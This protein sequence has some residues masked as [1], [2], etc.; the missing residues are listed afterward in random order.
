MA[1][2]RA[3]T[4]QRDDLFVDAS[5]CLRMRF[6]QSSCRR[7][8]D[9]CPHTAVSLDAG[10]A[11]DQQRC[12]ACLLCTA[13]CPTGALEQHG[14]FAA[15]LAQLSKVPEAVLG[16]I[17]TKE[18]SNATVA[19]LGGLSAEH[20]LALHQTLAGRLTLNL[21][22]CSDC[23]NSPMTVQLRQRL[24]A[25]SATGLS[26][27][28]CRIDLAE[29]AQDLHYRAE[30]V[31]RRG[32]FTAFRTSL[33]SSAAVILSS[34]SEQDIRGSA[35]AAKRVPIRRELL[36]RVR[37]TLSPVLQARLEQY[38]DW[39]VG[40]DLGCTRCQGCVATCPTGALQT[41]DNEEAPVF[42]HLLCTGCGLCQ[43]FCL[44]KAV[45][46]S[47]GV[48]TENARENIADIRK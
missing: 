29:S 24:D 12:R 34:N 37:S 36:N 41:R 21:S 20:L 40:C 31:D 2:S 11:I 43:E 22:V 1:E 15:C 35:Y 47:R 42:D 32:F 3:E 8:A 6:S 39:Q 30:T 27:G 33:F 46:I 23:P 5:R 45:R 10:L 38:F 48:C 7:C 4:G 44:D 9:V 16:C 26:Y 25:L 13:V 18:C 14:D 28:N 17:R 19:C